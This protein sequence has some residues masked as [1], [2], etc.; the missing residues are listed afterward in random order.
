[1]EENSREAWKNNVE[2]QIE[3]LKQVVKT[4]LKWTSEKEKVRNQVAAI[5]NRAYESNSCLESV[6]VEVANGEAV[7]VVVVVVDVDEN[8]SSSVSAT[9][10]RGMQPSKAPLGFWVKP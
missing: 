4:F 3:R 8:E 7:V 10:L 6:D 5:G 1:M 9:A 2:Q